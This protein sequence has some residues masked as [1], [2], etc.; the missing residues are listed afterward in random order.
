MLFK[1]LVCI[2]SRPSESLL[3]KT[4][5]KVRKYNR[6]VSIECLA[7]SDWSS[8]MQTSEES[9]HSAVPHATVQ[10]NLLVFLSKDFPFSFDKDRCGEVY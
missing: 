8:S 4:S 2:S 1:S 9:T 6:S 7:S 10:G 5:V 3:S